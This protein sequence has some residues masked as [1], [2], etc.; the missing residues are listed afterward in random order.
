M[1]RHQEEFSKIKQ[2]QTNTGGDNLHADCFVTTIEDKKQT[3]L[4]ETAISGIDI[5]TLLVDNEQSWFHIIY[6]KIN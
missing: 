5:D 4:G 2:E 6:I 3:I 1:Q